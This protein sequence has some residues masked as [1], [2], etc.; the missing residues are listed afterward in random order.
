MPWKDSLNLHPY[1]SLVTNIPGARGWEFHCWACRYY[2]NPQGFFVC[3]CFLGPPPQHMKVPRLRVESKLQLLAYS[4]AT[5]TAM[6][7]LSRIC[8][9]H[10]SSRQR[11]IPNP[12]SKTRDRTLDLMVPSWI[13][14]HC[15]MT[16]TPKINSL[17]WIFVYVRKGYMRQWMWSYSGN[18]ITWHRHHD[19]QI[20]K[21][22]RVLSRYVKV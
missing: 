16:R 7:D 13:H 4:I 1:Y 6:W 5:A 8:D 19:L 14:F 2:L 17:F 20:L 18:R 15:A 21:Y 3:F 12:L 9:L 11:W 22:V 10:H